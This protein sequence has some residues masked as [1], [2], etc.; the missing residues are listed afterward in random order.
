MVEV[1]GE[2]MKLVRQSFHTKDAGMTNT[3]R[4]GRK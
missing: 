3:S 1:V 2:R 4:G